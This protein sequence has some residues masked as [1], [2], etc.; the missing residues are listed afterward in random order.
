MCSPH[1]DLK[2]EARGY[3]RNSLFSHS[4]GLIRAKGSRWGGHAPF[5]TCWQQSRAGC[6]P[7]GSYPRS[8]LKEGPETHDCQDLRAGRHLSTSCWDP[9]K[10]LRWDES[11]P[12]W[13]FAA[14]TPTAGT[15]FWMNWMCELEI[16]HVGHTSVPPSVISSSQLKLLL[17]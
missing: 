1:T 8:V 14:S 15:S 9:L 11:V 2:N 5:S 7:A 13:L 17:L 6:S 16:C 4:V 10:R 12:L 3:I